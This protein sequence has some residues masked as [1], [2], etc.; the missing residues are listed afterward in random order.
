MVKS[1]EVLAQGPLWAFSKQDKILGRSR[2]EGRTLVFGLCPSG[3]FK[4][5]TEASRRVNLEQ[6]ITHLLPGG[7]LSPTSPP[8]RC[9]SDSHPTVLC[10]GLCREHFGGS[11]DLQVLTSAETGRHHSLRAGWGLPWLLSSCTV[12]RGAEHAQWSPP[13]SVDTAT[14]NSFPQS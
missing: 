5:N 6:L 8:S 3:L 11:P 13:P 7:L 10:Q 1:K 9:R 4:G 2:T 14:G 12:W